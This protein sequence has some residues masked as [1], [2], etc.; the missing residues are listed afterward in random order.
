[1]K[2]QLLALSLLL[3]VCIVFVSCAKE[4][5]TGVWANAT[6]T[7]D[8]TYGTGATTVQV[9]VKAEDRSVTL[10]IKTDKTTLGD[11][12][13]EHGLIAGDE[14]EY[15]LYVKKVIG[16]T[17]DYDVDQ[18][19]WSFT[20]NGEMMMTGV[21]GETISDGAHYELTYTK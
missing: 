15:G 16:I 6:V 3:C 17:A 1:M 7:E 9:E 14:S 11:A 19:Y 20:K 18:S 10:T 12:L 4:A 13:L 21:D 8:T 5:P 2:K